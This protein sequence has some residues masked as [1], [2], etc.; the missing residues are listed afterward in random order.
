MEELTARTFAGNAYAPLHDDLR[1][2]LIALFEMRWSEVDLELPQ[3]DLSE[4]RRL[5]L[6]A[7]SEFILNHPDYYALFTC[8]MF[9]G[10]VAI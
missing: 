10:K 1:H 5:C 4:Y 3:E 7:S 2:A 9:C 8:S 6:P